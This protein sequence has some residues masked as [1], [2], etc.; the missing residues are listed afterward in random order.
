MHLAKEEEG[1]LSWRP[2]SPTL[3]LA[4]HQAMPGNDLKRDICSGPALH[5]REISGLIY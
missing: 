2:R 4:M 5:Q 1:R 3:L